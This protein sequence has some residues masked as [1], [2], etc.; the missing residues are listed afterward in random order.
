MDVKS[1]VRK[2]ISATTSKLEFSVAC[3]GKPRRRYH[4]SPRHKSARGTRRK[5]RPVISSRDLFERALLTNRAESFNSSDRGGGWISAD[6][7]KR[8]N[9]IFSPLYSS[10]PA[11][12]FILH[13][14]SEH[15]SRT[16]ACVCASENTRRGNFYYPIEIFVLFSW[17]EKFQLARWFFAGTRRKDGWKKGGKIGGREKISSKL[18]VFLE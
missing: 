11:H 16:C 10:K 8:P 14:V 12:L 15:V 7:T 4:D 1:H 3:R 2:G 17:F 9:L 18:F 5:P 6:D 13:L